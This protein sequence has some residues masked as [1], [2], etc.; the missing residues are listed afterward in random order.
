MRETESMK[1]PFLH[2]QFYFYFFQI[3]LK[4]AIV[5]LDKSEIKC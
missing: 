2:I 1:Q 3:W 4:I 5:Y